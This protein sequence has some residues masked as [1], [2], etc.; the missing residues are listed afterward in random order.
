MKTST[1]RILTTHTGSLPR[2]AALGD[3]RDPEAVRAA[4]QETVRR[5]VDAGVDIVNDGEVSK[6][7]YATYVTER[8]SG[9]GGEAAAL[10]LR[11]FDAFPE[12]AQKTWG[13]P[14]MAAIMANPS[15][16]GPVAYID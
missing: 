14:D 16:D 8:L 4:V 7:S 2:P 12:F 5:Q 1:E 11:D 10:Q 15:C 3:R 13:D 9:F 6:P